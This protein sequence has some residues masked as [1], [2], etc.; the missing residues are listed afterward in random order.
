MLLWIIPPFVS[1]TMKARGTGL[2]KDRHTVTASNPGETPANPEVS[3]K[4]ES[5]C[6]FLYI[7]EDTSY[8]QGF[9]G[10]STTEKLICRTSGS[11]E[12]KE[13]KDIWR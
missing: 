7:Q 5:V 3:A 13:R 1:W 2:K 6:F 8:F 12:T 10:K 11:T 4:L 9:K